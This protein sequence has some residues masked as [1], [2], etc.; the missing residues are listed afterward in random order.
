MDQEYSYDYIV[1]GGGS[2]GLSTAKR[3][4]KHGKKVAV[5][6]YVKPSPQGNFFF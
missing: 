5:I 6:D 3:A 1:V 4:A 2:G